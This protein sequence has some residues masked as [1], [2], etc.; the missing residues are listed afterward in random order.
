[1]KVCE[2]RF[3][4]S[5]CGFKKRRKRIEDKKQEELG[6]KA[7]ETRH[8]KMTRGRGETARRRL[9]VRIENSGFSVQVSA[10]VF[11]FPDT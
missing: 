7:L 10:F 8:N 1:V 5:Y 6:T 9:E 4:I 3:R 11:L 2:V